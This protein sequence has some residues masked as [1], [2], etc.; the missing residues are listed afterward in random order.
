MRGAAAGF[1]VGLVAACDLAIA[2][3]SAFFTLA[4]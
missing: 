2:A 4:Y 3:R 1:G